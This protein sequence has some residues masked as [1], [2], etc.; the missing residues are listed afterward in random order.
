M[1]FEQLIISANEYYLQE[2]KAAIIKVPT[3][4]K[5]VRGYNHKTKRSEVIS[6]FPEQKSTV[7]FAGQI[8]NQP[9]WFET[10]SC[11]NKTN[12]PLSKIEAHQLEWLRQ[13]DSMGGIAFILFEIVQ[14]NAFYYMSY[15][16]LKRF[17]AENERK[18]IP[19]DFFEKFCQKV[20]FNRRGI[21]D[22]LKAVKIERG[23]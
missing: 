6:A 22:Y 15:K 1:D 10:K 20:N 11:S 14:H 8:G 3:S 19:L 23:I 12:F 9:A 7:D 5:I 18:S 13:V 16:Q 21:L 2:K 17:M 4:F